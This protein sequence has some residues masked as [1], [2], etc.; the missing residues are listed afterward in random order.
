MP[1]VQPSA[2]GRQQGARLGWLALHEV[3]FHDAQPP[4]L[5]LCPDPTFPSS[6]PRVGRKSWMKAASVPLSRPPSKASTL[7]WAPLA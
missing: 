5:S 7:P 2:S 4:C 6:C 3:A 1:P